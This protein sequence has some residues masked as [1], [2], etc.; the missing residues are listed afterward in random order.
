MLA[1]PMIED[2]SAIQS[3]CQNSLQQLGKW[4]STRSVGLNLAGLFKARENVCRMLLVALA[5]PE[6][7]LF[8]RR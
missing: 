5:T 4:L 6:L 3:L 8:S 1:Q 2:S 7:S